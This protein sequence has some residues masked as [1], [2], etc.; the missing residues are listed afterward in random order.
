MTNLCAGLISILPG[1]ICVKHYSKWRGICVQ[2]HGTITKS[3]LSFSRSLRNDSDYQYTTLCPPYPVL[4]LIIYYFGDLRTPWEQVT[5]STI[6][7]NSRPV[8][9]IHRDMFH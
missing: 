4:L 6:T 8:L 5:N 1:C 9:G 7:S 2:D 3:L